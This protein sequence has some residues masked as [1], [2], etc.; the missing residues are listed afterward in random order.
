MKLDLK[1]TPKLTIIFVLFAFVLLLTVGV[2]AYRSGQQA[3]IAATISELTAT[4]VEKEAALDEWIEDQQM[5][6]GILTALP[7][8]HQALSNLQA[9]STNAAGS[10]ESVRQ[11]MVPWLGPHGFRALLILDPVTGQVLVATDPS[12]EG[13]F[14]ENRPYFIHGREGPYVQDPYY[15]LVLREPAMTIATPIRSEAG[16]LLGVLVGRLNL[17]SLNE[18]IQRGSGI[19]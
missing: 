12:Q 18:I 3:L 10:L 16:Q 5:D 11:E 6:L 15:S 4:A 1:L 14:K 13:K 19:R 8:M 2:M 9:G 17:E 7:T